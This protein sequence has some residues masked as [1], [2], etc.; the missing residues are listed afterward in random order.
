MAAKP[1]PPAD[2]LRQLLDLDAETGVL[3]WRERTPE[4]FPSE[5][6]C[7]PE[8]ICKTWNK[9]HAGKV[10]G[11]SHSRYGHLQVKLPVGKFL[12]HRLVWAMHFGTAP[13]EVI[14]HMDG[15]GANNRPDN[16]RAAS[17]AQ[18]MANRKKQ[19][20]ECSSRFKGV[21][22]SPYGWIAKIGHEG[23]RIHIGIFASEEDAA[24]A[25]DR[26]AVRLFGAYAQLN[27]PSM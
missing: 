3:R 10:A 15:D 26:E 4:M 7:A 16:L 2:Y 22:R 18:N 6:R 23:K 11:Y 5:S 9:L 19:G 25:Y 24:N 13:P 17:L 20:A 27:M 14:D 1:I 12:A 21:H 8:V